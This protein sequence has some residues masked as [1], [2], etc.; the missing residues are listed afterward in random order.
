[1]KIYFAADHAGFAL[2]Q[3]LLNFVRG[4]LGLEVED[5]GAFAIDANDDYP[6]IIA[7]AARALSLDVASGKDSRAILIG[8]SGQGEAIVAN[9][10]ALSQ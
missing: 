5:C 4:D 9:R 1:M 2:K 8:A 10:F 6:D 3:E 7:K